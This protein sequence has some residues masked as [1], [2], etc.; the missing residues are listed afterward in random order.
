MGVDLFTTKKFRYYISLYFKG[1]FVYTSSFFVINSY[2]V[3]FE[4]MHSLE[5]NQATL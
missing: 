1:D 4:I 3:A 2:Y 5:L